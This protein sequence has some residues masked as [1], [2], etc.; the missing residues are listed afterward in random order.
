V[1][2]DALFALQPHGKAVIVAGAQAIYLHTGM[3]DIGIAPYTTD[4][5][6]AVDPTILGDEPEIEATMRSAGF[7]ILP[8]PKGQ[9]G[10][11]TASVTIEGEPQVVPIDLIVPDAF[12]PPGGRRSARIAPHGAQAA[13]KAEGLEAVLVDHAPMTI[14][15]LDSSDRSITVEVAGLAAMLVAKPTRFA[16]AWRTRTSI[17]SATRMPPTSTASCRPRHHATLAA[18]SATSVGIPLP[19]R[20]R[21]PPSRS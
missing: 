7:E 4:G 8:Q 6:I 13:R 15:A 5:D 21:R 19:G 9:P 12:A 3:N 10:I 2:L 17:A 11:W 16:I 18:R 20:S 1:L 14:S